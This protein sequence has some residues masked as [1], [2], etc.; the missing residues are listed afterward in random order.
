MPRGLKP[1][2]YAHLKS[3]L[4]VLAASAAARA[5]TVQLDVATVDLKS[6]QRRAPVVQRHG[7]VIEIDVPHAP[8]AVTDEMMSASEHWSRD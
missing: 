7:N 8:A 3:A 1:P 2:L 6:A 4:R 5:Q